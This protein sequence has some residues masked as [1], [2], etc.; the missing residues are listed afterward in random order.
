MP[1]G[2]AGIESDIRA[3]VVAEVERWSLAHKSAGN[4]EGIFV[5]GDVA[6]HGQSAEF[7]TARNWFRLL[8]EAAGCDVSSVYVVAGNHDVDRAPIDE[9]AELRALHS[10]L[11]AEDPNHTGDAFR[12]A[13]NDPAKGELLLKPLAAFRAFAAPYECDISA[14]SLQWQRRISLA[15]GVSLRIMGITTAV[16]SDADDKRGDG[17][18]ILGDFQSMISEARSCIT[19]VLMHHPPSWL[20]DGAYAE[21]RIRVRAH[22][23]L[24][25]HEHNFDA[26]KTDPVVGHGFM[27]VRAGALHPDKE[28]GDWQNPWD[29][30]FNWIELEYPLDNDI[31]H[32]KV[33]LYPW[34]WDNQRGHFEE[35]QSNPELVVEIQPRVDIQSYVYAPIDVANREGTGYG[36]MD[37]IPELGQGERDLSSGGVK[38]MSNMHP[39][40]A[41]AIYFRYRELP[42]LVRIALLGALKLTINADTQDA[43]SL[44]LRT[45]L[46]E[47]QDRGIGQQF[48]IAVGD[49]YTKAFGTSGRP[50]AE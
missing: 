40:D 47:V 42:P 31:E 7:E 15:D 39:L 14:T 9:N 12:H 17:G 35:T 4:V 38:V 24:S 20:H 16:I 3:Q 27:Y 36:P 46:S 50:R 6:N 13:L 48:S 1:V 32:A 43:T 45:T 19:I 41:K 23:I 22:V 5:T 21:Q 10:S 49:A 26:G 33:R 28:S 34:R 18:L 30:R 2:L 8:T 25:G 11:R 44:G 37:A 29:P